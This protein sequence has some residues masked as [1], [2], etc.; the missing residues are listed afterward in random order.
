[1]LG[2]NTHQS[3]FKKETCRFLNDAKIDNVNTNN[4]KDTSKK[5]NIDHYDIIIIGGGIAG[6]AT[7]A[8]LIER[9]G[10]LLNSKNSSS[11]ICILEK[12]K[13]L[14]P[15]GATL[16][17]FPNGK[18]ALVS[19]S[20]DISE[21]VL[22]SGVEYKGTIHKDINGNI[23]DIIHDIERQRQR[24]NNGGGKEANKA[25][26]I[27]WFLL[28][29]YLAEAIPFIE[30][31]DDNNDNDDNKNHIL[32]LGHKLESF[33]YDQDGEE[34]VTLHVQDL[35]NNKRVN[36]TCNLL[37]GADGI[38][39]STR[40]ML[41]MNETKYK[42]HDRIMYRAMLYDN[43]FDAD[44]VA[45]KDGYTM[46]YRCGKP[47]KVFAIRQLAKHIYGFT[48][49]VTAPK[50]S[51]DTKLANFQSKKERLKHHFEDYPDDVQHIIDCVSMDAIYEN[52]VWDIN[53]LDRWSRDNIPVVLIGDA[54]HAMTPK[55]GQGA[56]MGLEDATELAK[57]IGPIFRK[58][59]NTSL[60]VSATTTNLLL[61]A[62][63]EF[64]SL[65]V[66]RVREVHNVSRDAVNKEMKKDNSFRDRIYQWKPSFFT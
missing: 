52:E 36:M 22:N 34:I 44:T 2:K 53:F 49:C 5:K 59:A 30:E 60:Q 1:M 39:S 47:G 6:L 10:V 15:I 40:D 46:A 42:Y 4:E 38:K 17:L 31:N 11:S 12:A 3:L 19:I 16:G 32:K 13:E 20:S 65:R 51:D 9:E 63:K 35:K 18:S 21:K 14:K 66:D 25:T 26:V 41:F 33:T 56:N 62:L 61:R 54:A 28:Q 55:L 37:I 7:A 8:A 45:P 23:N 64:E 27:A 57:C 48:A 43:E 24:R 58:D 50:L 29:K